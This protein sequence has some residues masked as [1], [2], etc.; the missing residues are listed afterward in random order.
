MNAVFGLSDATN[1]DFLGMRVFIENEAKKNPERVW[2]YKDGKPMKAGNVHIE[3]MVSLWKN[4]K[5]ST[6]DLLNN[7]STLY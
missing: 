1:V 2:F 7:L 5:G 6:L 4:Y 3:K